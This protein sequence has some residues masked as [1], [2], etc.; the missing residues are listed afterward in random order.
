M[1]INCVICDK[2]ITAREPI[3]PTTMG[4]YAHIVCADGQ[5]KR[6]Y[7]RRKRAALLHA[8]LVIGIIAGAWEIGGQGWAFGAGVFGMATHVCLQT[9]W[10]RH[11]MLW[12]RL[13]WMMHR[14][15]H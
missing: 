1:T 3:V 11:M 8:I 14:W 9:I 6:A 7:F 15:R 10:W 13:W 12:L 2:P 5:A 4:R